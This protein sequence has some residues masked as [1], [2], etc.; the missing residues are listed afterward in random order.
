M[1]TRDVLEALGNSY[2]QEFAPGVA[3]DQADLISFSSTADIDIGFFKDV[4]ETLD[5][6]AL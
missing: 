4:L 6:T 1:P 3:E 5:T 2:Y